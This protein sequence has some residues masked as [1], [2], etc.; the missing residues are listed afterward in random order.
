MSSNR[1]CVEEDPMASSRDWRL[2]LESFGRLLDEADNLLSDSATQFLL[3]MTADDAATA[4]TSASDGS[5]GY[6]R[7]MTSMALL[8]DTLN[9]NVTN[10]L[11]EL[12]IHYKIHF[13]SYLT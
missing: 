4:T 8:F 2:V 11:P 10:W 3:S 7:D 1:E 9:W 6:D 13:T 5:C 12:Q